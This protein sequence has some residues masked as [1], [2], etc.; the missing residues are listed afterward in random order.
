MTDSTK[1]P[2]DEPMTLAAACEDI[3]KNA[4]GPDTLMAEASRGRLKMEKIG[5]R[6]FVTRAAIRE[7]RKLC[8]VVQSPRE[9]GFGSSREEVVTAKL[10]QPSGS[11]ETERIKLARDSAQLKLQ[12]LKGALQN[13]SRKSTSQQSPVVIPLK[14]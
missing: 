6:W 2:D 5:R 10:S 9:H 4:I 13:T 1:L 12:K 14:S 7:M 8:E 11:S 3:F